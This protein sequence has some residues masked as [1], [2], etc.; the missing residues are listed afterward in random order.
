MYRE[1]RARWATF[2]G[3]L[4]SEGTAVL[5]SEIWGRCIESV[6]RAALRSKVWVLCDGVLIAGGTS[7]LYNALRRFRGQLRLMIW[8]GASRTEGTLLHAE[9]RSM[10]WGGALRSERTLRFV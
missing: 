1:L 6:G 8:G 7:V 4:K 3:A 5:R 9:L 10:I 2:K